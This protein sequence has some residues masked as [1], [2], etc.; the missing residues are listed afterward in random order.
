MG[1]QIV[2]FLVK[3]IIKRG[4]AGDQK[5]THGSGWKWGMGRSCKQNKGCMKKQNRTLQPPNGEKSN[6]IGL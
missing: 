5:N 1:L 6:K 2:I 4:Y 3:M